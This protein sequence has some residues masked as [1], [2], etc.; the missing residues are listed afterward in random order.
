MKYK[1]SIVNN[2]NVIFTVCTSHILL[3]KLIATARNVSIFDVLFLTEFPFGTRE[4][5][6]ENALR[7]VAALEAPK[8]GIVSV[9]HENK[10]HPSTIRHLSSTPSVYYRYF[11]HISFSRRGKK[12]A[13]RLLLNFA[14]RPIAFRTLRI[15]SS[16]SDADHAMTRGGLIN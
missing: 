13:F 6:L 2:L 11:S 1:L 5:E 3:E 12:G 9:F 16:H 8:N 10:I 15:G 14:F 4:H 7:T